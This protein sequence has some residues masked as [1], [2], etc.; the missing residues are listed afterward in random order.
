MDRKYIIMILI[1]LIVIMMCYYYYYYLM[2]SKTEHE[3]PGHGVAGQF[4]LRD[5]QTYEAL[6]GRKEHQFP[7]HGV[8]GQFG[9]R[10]E[11][12]YSSGSGQRYKTEADTST[13]LTI[14]TGDFNR[15]ELSYYMRR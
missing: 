5:F 15:R 14:P 13:E 8:A 9:L 6:T 12:F 4:G 11:E 10:S 2:P 7:G 1:I 3:H